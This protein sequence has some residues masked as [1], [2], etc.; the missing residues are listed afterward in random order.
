[1][2]TAGID[3]GVDSVKVVVLKDGKVVARSGT[4]SGG[5]DRGASAEKAFKEALAAAGIKPAEVKKVVATGQGK[6]D[7]HVAAQRVVE[8]VADARGARYLYPSARAVLDVGADQMRLVIMDDAGKIEEAVLNQKCAAGIGVFLQSISR[9]MGL[10]LEEMGRM[11]GKAADQV[12]VNDSC[13]VFAGLDSIALLQDETPAGDIAQ[14]VHE[15]MAARI[16][17]MLNDKV[18]P[19][20]N[21]TVMVG[22]VAKNEGIVKALK[23]RSGVKFM[24]PD[25]PEYAGALGAALIAAD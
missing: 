5:A 4:S 14:A 10:S 12:I 18:L 3:V 22:G 19:P 2:I 1:M 15:A 8:P 20:K 23:K 16:N 25:Q 17:A 13:A 11:T 6:N 24:I 9:R 21:S 7:A